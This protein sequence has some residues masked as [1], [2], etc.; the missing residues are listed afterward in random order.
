MLGRIFD[1]ALEPLEGSLEFGQAQLEP[2]EGLL[3][4]F[5]PFVVRL[6]RRRRA[7]CRRQVQAVRFDLDGLVVTVAP[8]RRRRFCSRC[9]Q[10]R[11]ATHDTVLSRWHLD[12]GGQ[13]CGS[14][15]DADASTSPAAGT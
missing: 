8:G 2:G 4:R 13:R 6:A 5:D 9:G 1:I 12:L 14:R 3:D 7:A 15:R 11:A 10:L